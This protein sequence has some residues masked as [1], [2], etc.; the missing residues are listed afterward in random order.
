MEIIG[1]I[2]DFLNKKVR[3]LMIFAENL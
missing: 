2:V 1:K 3:F